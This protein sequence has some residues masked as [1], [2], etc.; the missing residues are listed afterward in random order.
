MIRV[1]WAV[2]SSKL[3]FIGAAAVDDRDRDFKQ[4]EVNQQLTAM[5]NGSRSKCSIR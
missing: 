3:I 4:P 5:V 2:A 1:L